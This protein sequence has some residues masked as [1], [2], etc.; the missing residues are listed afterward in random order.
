M[1]KEA[2]IHLLSIEFV[3]SFYQNGI[4]KCSICRVHCLPGCD[5][6]VIPLLR[7]V[8][9]FFHAAKSYVSGQLILIILFFIFYDVESCQGRVLWTYPWRAKP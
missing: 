5:Q 8:L 3:S 4:E 7:P 9:S 1:M 6:R 2:K